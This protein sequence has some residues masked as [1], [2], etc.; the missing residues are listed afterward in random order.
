MSN[1]SFKIVI[2]LCFIFVDVT[3]LKDVVLVFPDKVV[4]FHFAGANEKIILLGEASL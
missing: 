2:T 1:V 4:C 3:N